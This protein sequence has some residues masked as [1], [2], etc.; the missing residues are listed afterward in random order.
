VHLLEYLEKKIADSQGRNRL[1]LD[2]IKMAQ[3]ACGVL[4]QSLAPNRSPRLNTEKKEI[5]AKA[6]I[7]L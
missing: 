4:K 6:K 3:E 7:R 2:K 5:Q 1:L